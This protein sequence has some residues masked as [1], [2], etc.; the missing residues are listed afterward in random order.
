MNHEQ[1]QANLQLVLDWIDA[2]RR[3]NIDAIAEHFHPD[4]AWEDVGGGVACEGREQVLAWLRVAPSQPTDVDALDLLAGADH[5]VLGVCNHAR[6]E[7]AGVQLDG[8]LW[9]SR[10]ART[11]SC[12]SVITPTRQRTRRRWARLPVALTPAL[13][14]A[15]VEPRRCSELGTESLCQGA[16]RRDTSSRPGRS[17][18][19]SWWLPVPG[20]SRSL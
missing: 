10:S 5:A 12:I 6:Q 9:S 11:R 8:Q 16:P 7:L 20:W 15:S 19:R 13:D 14:E 1:A 18:L 2:L 17:S 3:G 4:V